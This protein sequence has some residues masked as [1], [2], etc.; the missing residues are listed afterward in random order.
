MLQIFPENTVDVTYTQ[1]KLKRSPSSSARTIK[2]NNCSTEKCNRRCD[3]C[4]NFLVAST[5][6]FVMLPNANTK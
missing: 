2:E 5:E 6:F 1:K 3:I 4:K